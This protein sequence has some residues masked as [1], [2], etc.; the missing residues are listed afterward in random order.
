MSIVS[1]LRF[2]RKG[3]KDLFDV[4]AEEQKKYLDSFPEPNNDIDRSLFQYKCQSFF[5]P[6]WKA[7][8]FNIGAFMAFF[9]VLLLEWARSVIVHRCQ[10]KDAISEF[11]GM[12]ECVPEELSRDFDVWHSN[13]SVKGMLTLNDLVFVLKV[14]YKSFPNV[15]FSLKILLKTAQYSQKIRMYNPRAFIVHCEFSFTSSVLTQF[16]EQKGVEHI[17]VMHGEKL[18]HIYDS[19]FRFSKC[20][21]W[22]EFYKSLFVK[23]RAYSKQFVIRVPSSLRIET[24]NYLKPEFYADYKY[25]LGE[26]SESEFASIVESMNKL[27]AQG[28]SVKYRVHPRYLSDLSIIEK[29]VL[30]SEI[31]NPRLV[32][33]LESVSNCTYAVSNYSTVLSQAFMS[34][35]KVIIDDVTFKSLYEKL[36]E[37]DYWLAK[38]NCLRLSEVVHID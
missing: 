26:F 30:P 5:W 6:K 20:Y 38:E 33:I 1:F 8:V 11:A 12:E 29:Y 36:A 17:D 37:Y 19:F 31:E 25:Y 3:D 18:Y 14:F 13:N 23:L 15:Y 28:K 22:S 27:K 32:S 10:Q 9:P 16:C 34:G 35:K 2:L 21:V 24:N 7:P 4:P